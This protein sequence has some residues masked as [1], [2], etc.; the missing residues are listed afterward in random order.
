LILHQVHHRGEM[1]VL[2]RMAGLAV[3]G[4]F[5]PTRE[6]WAQYGMQ[7]PSV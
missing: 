7:P 1:I 2:M 6:E 3:P 5:G 4:I